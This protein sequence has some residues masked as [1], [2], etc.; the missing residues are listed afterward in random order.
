MLLCWHH[1][2]GLERACRKSPVAGRARHAPCRFRLHYFSDPALTPA[3]FFC[4]QGGHDTPCLR[5]LTR[6]DAADAGQALGVVGTSNGFSGET[7]MLQ[8][9][10][11]DGNPPPHLP[12]PCGFSRGAKRLRGWFETVGHL[13][14]STFLTEDCS[15]SASNHSVSTGVGQKCHHPAVRAP[16]PADVLVR[17]IATPKRLWNHCRRWPETRDSQEA[18][19]ISP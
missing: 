2:A 5:P 11:H 17:M 9:H 13:T 8:H 7:P 12:R 4:V 6:G 10:R 18:P 15:Q 16:S 1:R 3:A 19:L 14:A